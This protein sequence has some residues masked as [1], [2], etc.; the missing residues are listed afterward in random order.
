MKGL[1]FMRYFKEK[2]KMKTTQISFQ[3]TGFF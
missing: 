2:V 3:K 1:I